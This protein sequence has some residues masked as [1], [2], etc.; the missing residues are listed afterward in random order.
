MMLAPH[1]PFDPEESPLSY[2]ARLAGIHT[3]GRLIP[4][5]R[6]LE[7]EPEDMVSNKEEA[8]SR[9]AELSGVP[10]GDLRANAP[11]PLG[12]RTYVLRGELVTAEFLANP[13]TMFCPACLAE[14]DRGAGRRGRWQWTLSVVR[15]CPRHKIA[16]VRRTK[17]RWDDPFH[18]LDC[19]VP[20]RGEQLE[21]L[22]AQSPKRSISPLQ[23][24]VIN[25]LNGKAGPDWLDAQ[26]LEQSVRASELLGALIAYGPGQ[27]LPEL[28]FNDWDHAGRLGF[29]FTSGGEVRIREALD[30]QLRQFDNANGT[31]G[32]QRIFGCLYKALAYPN[33]NKEP[34]DIARI[35][36]AFIIENIALSAGTNVLGEKLCERQLH[37]VASLAHEQD[38]DSRTLNDVLVAA[39]MIPEDA[40]SHYTI[41]AQEGR[42]VAGRVKRM[43]HVISL[44]HA[45][46]CARPLVDQLFSDRLL[47]PIYYGRP[48]TRGRTQKAVDSEEITKLVGELHAKAVEMDVEA[49][50]FAPISKVA[51]K[52]KVPAVTVVHMILGGF[53]ERVFR[54]T[55][56][57][58]VAALRVDP[59]E[60]NRQVAVCTEGF[61]PMAAFGALK[62]PR[63]VGWLLTDRCG[64]EVSLPVHWIAGPSGDRKIPRFDPVILADFKG[65]YI[66]P[67][68]IAERYGLRVGEVVGRLKRR[69]IRPVLPRAEIGVDFYRGSILELDLFT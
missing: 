48:G 53:L 68:Q 9:L 35:L 36:R 19:R 67:A 69:G 40:P 47:T 3:G 63:D 26:S 34:G 23:K 33:S 52:A 27:R 29:E 24:Y 1:V 50:G 18:E 5:L 8:L 30:V 66:H 21:A 7:F 55:G 62:I 49:D 57:N 42:N 11:V 10:I 14:D 60:V 37:T 43:V 39:G 64:E 2:A 22:I 31:P 65:R 12:G 44:P 51:E 25:R 4:F 13:H 56:Q 16:L 45:L 61:S 41:P 38:L 54:R 17:K 46:G 28:T 32:A 59:V 6:D 20:E 15:T 58:G